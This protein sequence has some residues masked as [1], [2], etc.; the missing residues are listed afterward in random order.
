MLPSLKTFFRTWMLVAA[1][2]VH[3]FDSPT[4]TRLFGAEE[5]CQLLLFLADTGA[6]FEKV[7]LGCDS[8]S[9]YVRFC[10]EFGEMLIFL[11]F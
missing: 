8:L 7:A 9:A 2:K 4:R 3:V 10:S 1:F 5:F 11:F 6:G